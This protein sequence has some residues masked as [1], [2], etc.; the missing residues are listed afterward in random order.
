MK[1][2]KNKLLILILLLMFA[3]TSSFIEVDASEASDA[4]DAADSIYSFTWI[5]S[6]VIQH[7]GNFAYTDLAINFDVDESLKPYYINNYNNKNPISGI[8]A[9]ENNTN[10]Y[11]YFR[12]GSGS[13]YSIYAIDYASNRVDWGQSYG[14]PGVIYNIILDH[15]QDESKLEFTYNWFDT[16]G[17]ISDI[18]YRNDV[19]INQSW[20]NDYIYFP[21]YEENILYSIDDGITWASTINEQYRFDNLTNLRFKNNDANL[22][23]LIDTEGTDTIILN[24]G[25][26]SE[27]LLTNEFKT[28]FFGLSLTSLNTNDVIFIQNHNMPFSEY[29]NDMSFSIDNG[30]TFIKFNDI[31]CK[32]FVLSCFKTQINVSNIIFKN[33]SFD[34]FLTI[35]YLDNEVKIDPNTTYSVNISEDTIFE[36]MLEQLSNKVIFS[37]TSDANFII[38]G[39][40]FYYQINESGYWIPIVSSATPLPY[41][42]EDVESIKFKNNSDVYNLV[43]AGN[44][45]NIPDL[46]PKSES[47]LFLIP[48]TDN[49]IIT[50][51]FSLSIPEHQHIFVNG[52]CECG[53]ID[54]NYVLSHEHIFINGECECGELDPNRPSDTGGTDIKTLIV[55]TDNPNMSDYNNLFYYKTN[56]M[57][58]YEV[59]N[60]TTSSTKSIMDLDTIQFKNLN[61]NAIMVLR[62]NNEVINLSYGQESKILDTSDIYLIN[63]QVSFDFNDDDDPYSPSDG[64]ENPD[65]VE[66]DDL[67]KWIQSQPLVVIVIGACL[68]TVV[69]L[70]V[71]KKRW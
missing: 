54:E 1:K 32:L 2:I 38:N 11:I 60:V 58:N 64:E 45:Q 24:P 19:T 65:D 3:F 29:G 18:V 66:D 62:Y 26:I 25:E 69:V 39:Y 63:L 52:S 46:A 48:E 42:L 22:S 70:L 47:E 9:S 15:S 6:N 49:R 8:S 37:N 40:N 13:R 28:Y 33:D 71:F 51:S 17:V 35:K 27:N 7:P 31:S 16:N 30:N 5:G 67:S 43:F 20:G 56:M 14:T 61:K 10:G 23:L 41:T 4:L 44:I 50:F 12:N 57:T 36:L 53:A 21:D 68:I 55:R 34:M 59:L